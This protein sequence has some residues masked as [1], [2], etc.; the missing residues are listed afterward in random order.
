[1]RFVGSIIATKS[2]GVGDSKNFSEATSNAPAS[3]SAGVTSGQSADPSGAASSGD[4]TDSCCLTDRSFQVY[5]APL[6]QVMYKNIE[7]RNRKTL[8]LDYLVSD[9][10][11]PTRKNVRLL[12]SVPESQTA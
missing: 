9:G 11:K 6:P 7:S 5:D 3:N 8:W 4:H 10:G 2:D 12:D 1:M